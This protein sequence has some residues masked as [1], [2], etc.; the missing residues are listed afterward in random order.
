VRKAEIP[1]GM[2]RQI[3]V[4]GGSSTIAES[5]DGSAVVTYTGVLILDGHTVLSPEQLLAHWI[6]QGEKA[7]RDGD[8]A[9]ARRDQAAIEQAKAHVLSYAHATDVVRRCRDRGATAAQTAQTLRTM[10][11]MVLEQGRAAARTAQQAAGFGAVD[12]LLGDVIGAWERT[13]RL[14][15]S[16]DHA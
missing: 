10:R 7:V 8:L 9:E 1:A 3:S 12:R 14:R 13:S 2:F 11:E 6:A 15:W 4:A 5:L 16:D